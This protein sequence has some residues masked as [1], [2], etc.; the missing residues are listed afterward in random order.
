MALA[1]TDLDRAERIARTIAV[2]RRKVEALA[3]ISEALSH[4]AGHHS[5]DLRYW[6]AEV[7]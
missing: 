5:V 6:R 4:V 1:A 3:A 7:P 2:V